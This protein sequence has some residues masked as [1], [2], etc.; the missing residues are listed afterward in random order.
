MP[1]IKP[2]PGVD[3]T[4]HASEIID[5]I[6]GFLED[7]LRKLPEGPDREH[8]RVL[9]GS[10]AGLARR[11]DQANNHAQQ[12][13][14]YKT[15]DGANAWGDA[16]EAVRRS[17]AE[18]GGTIP[19]V[20]SHSASVVAAAVS[21]QLGEALDVLVVASHDAWAAVEQAEHAL[22]RNRE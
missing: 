7:A 18:I 19:H 22:V 5:R 9:H 16:V 4:A 11:A 17:A 1:T 21:G 10:V 12:H 20:E 8:L 3:E 2:L 13:D 6:V 14:E 15:W